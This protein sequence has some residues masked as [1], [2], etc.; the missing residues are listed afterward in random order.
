[1]QAAQRS[2]CNHA[3]EYSADMADERSPSLVVFFGIAEKYP[4]ANQRHYRFMLEGL[5]RK[6]EADAYVGKVNRPAEG[7]LDVGS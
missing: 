1:M 4:G 3:L 5:R 6:F 7:G 2:E